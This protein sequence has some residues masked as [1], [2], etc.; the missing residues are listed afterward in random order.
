MASWALSVIRSLKTDPSGCCL[1]SCRNL[2]PHSWPAGM[3]I[4]LA[5]SA[6]GGGGN[7]HLCIRNAKAQG[8]LTTLGTFMHGPGPSQSAQ[9]PHS[10]PPGKAEPWADPLQLTE[11]GTPVHPGHCLPTLPPQPPDSRLLSGARWWRPFLQ[12]FPAPHSLFPWG[13]SKPSK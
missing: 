2:G 5:T 13:S 7:R 6:C 8:T 10:W 9:W 12:V 11:M 3:P 4:P 1:P